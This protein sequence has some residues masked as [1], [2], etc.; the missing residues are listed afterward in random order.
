MAPQESSGGKRQLV[1]PK[2]KLIRNLQVRVSKLKRRLT[3]SAEKHQCRSLMLEELKSSVSV[4][5]YTFIISQTC[6]SGIDD[7]SGTAEFIEQMDELFDMLNSRSLSHAKVFARAI[8]ATSTH[9]A[10]LETKQ[11]FIRSWELL[12]VDGRHAS[13]RPCKRGWLVTIAAVLQMWEQLRVEG[14][15]FLMTNRLNQDCLENS[16]SVIRQKGGFRDSPD[17]EQFKASAKALM[18]ENLMRSGQV[19]NCEEDFD[20]VLLC[21]GL[22][23]KHQPIKARSLL[24]AAHGKCF[25]GLGGKHQPIKARSLLFAAHGKCFQVSTAHKPAGASSFSFKVSTA[26]KQAS[27]SSFFLKGLGGKHQPIK[28]R[29]L[30]FAA[31][32]KC[33][34]VSMAHKPAGASSFSFKADLIANSIYQLAQLK[35]V[36]Q[37]CVDLLANDK[38]SCLSLA[39]LAAGHCFVFV[40]RMEMDSSS[41]SE[42]SN[43]ED[44]RLDFE[45]DDDNPFSYDPSASPPREAPAAAAFVIRRHV[46]PDAASEAEW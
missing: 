30:L 38:A 39:S 42:S 10:A 14:L 18:T 19:T 4:N 32:G 20:E 5:S 44:M 27:T 26:Y 7:Y 15:S 6:S 11:D 37:F 29:S 36:T 24:F 34:Q 28:A 12:T 22:G 1:T 8:T 2:T 46:D 41:S 17:T 45:D 13:S 16:F 31:H 25:Q 33:F 21:A 35:P 23:G 3:F 9:V 40:P 43:D